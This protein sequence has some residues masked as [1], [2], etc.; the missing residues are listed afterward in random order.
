MNNMKKCLIISKA[1]LMQLS[2][3]KVDWMAKNVN[4]VNN[5]IEVRADTNVKYQ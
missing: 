1:Y 2:I 3:V 5:I 4:P